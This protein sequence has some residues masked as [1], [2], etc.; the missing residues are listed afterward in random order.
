MMGYRTRIAAAIIAAAKQVYVGKRAEDLLKR[1]VF[2]PFFAKTG[3]PL[4]AMMLGALS[5]FVGEAA[6]Q[7]WPERPIHLVVG[8]G[9]GG[10][11]DIIVPG[12]GLSVL[13]RLPEV[14]HASAVMQASDKPAPFRTLAVGFS[15]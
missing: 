10:G 2:A 7:N 5:A 9:A 14:H 12:G 13:G 3:E 1:S 15:P 4:F 6:A 8:Y 11:T